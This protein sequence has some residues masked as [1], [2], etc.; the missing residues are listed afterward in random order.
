M[1]YRLEDLVDIPRFQELTDRLYDAAGIGS[2]IVTIDGEVLTGSGWQRICTDFH[3]KHPE[4]EKE[5]IQSDIAARKELSDG[6]PFCIYT[7]PR[8]LT[9]GSVPIVI[10]GEHIASVFAGQIFLEKPGEATEELFRE[11]A[12]HFGMDEEAYI[13]ALREVPVVPVERFRASLSFLANLAEMVASQGLQ[14][15]LELE[16]QAVAKIGSW[17]YDVAADKPTWSTEA[18]RIFG[19][20]PGTAEP[21]WE[22][23]RAF[24]HPDDWKALDEAVKGAVSEGRPYDE[25]YR[26]IHPDG[27]IRWGH[28]LGRA[29]KNE[30]GQIVR[31]VGSVQDITDRKRAE[32][33]LDY[34]RGLAQQYLDVAGVML[35]ALDVDQNVTLINPAGCEILGYS[36]D[37]IVGH[38]WFDEFLHSDDVD[39][40]KRV[41]SK[42]MS[43]DEALVEYYENPI[44]RKDGSRRIVAWHNSVLRDCDGEIRGLF[45]SGEDITERKEA[46]DD[47]RESEERL[48]AVLDATPFPVAIVDSDDDKVHFWSRSALAIFGHTAPAATKWY[49]IAYPD[50]VYRQEVIER[51]K[52]FLELARETG[53][54]VNTG[55]YRVTCADGTERIC[56]LWATFIPDRLVVT[57]NDVSERKKAEEE[58]ERLEQ[59]LYHSQKMES[60]G[61]LAGGVAHDFNN[62]LT[63]I[64]NYCDLVAG[65]LAEHDP[66]RVDIDEIRHAADRAADLTRQLLAF[67]RKQILRPRVIDVN[68]S[69]SRSEKML[70]RIIGEDIA[71]VFV[72]DPDLLRTRC[73]PGQVEQ[74][75]FNL[76]ANARDAMPRG[77]QLTLETKNVVVDGAYKKNH[78]HAETGRY[79]TLTVS[80]TGL[81]MDEHTRASIFEPFFTTKGVGKG[82]GLGLSTVY[83]IVKQHGGSVEV[84][85]ELGE[86]T[87]FVIYLPAVEEEAEEPEARTD[88]ATPHG[89]ETILLIEDDAALRRVALR[90]LEKHGF[91]V[92]EAANGGEALLLCESFQGPID[93]VLTDVVMPGMGGREC[94]ERLTTLRGDLQVLYMSGYT[95]DAI[96]HRGVLNEGT[97]LLQKPF[98]V[99]EL[100]GAIRQALDQPRP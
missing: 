81:G 1:K 74:I 79:V 62:L 38:N 3:R 55:E 23:H 95:E 84:T 96:A 85:S 15:K 64:S 80:D 82:T 8:G 34:E 43:G 13:E 22:D 36:K 44:L 45:S 24:I 87:T 5:C 27:N 26:I 37:E 94:F 91:N 56:E 47:L 98:T 17:V 76:A 57:L 72:P 67:S 48:R 14:R 12:R 99:K 61:R 32:E 100:L 11:Q 90:I 50:P 60:I 39:K 59:Q 92:L 63:V 31:V 86:G 29:V 49:E 20:D 73:D 42:I 30:N 53:K 28:S 58:R 4:I 71:L 89:D 41:F 51:W 77:G 16:A 10:E 54:P 69:L 6:E 83:G 46:T 2:A 52:P 65:P 93:L 21:R 78:P 40:V 9:D 7:C 33:R 68:E 18:F 66:M 97:R 19:R 70:Q 25:E 75:L 88:A 35:I